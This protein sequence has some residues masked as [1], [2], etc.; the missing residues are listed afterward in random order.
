MNGWAWPKWWVWSM[1]AWLSLAFTCRAFYI[2]TIDLIPQNAGCSLSSPSCSTR[3]WAV[4]HLWPGRWRRQR[5]PEHPSDRSGFLRTSVALKERKREETW[6][7]N[8]FRRIIEQRS[9]FVCIAL[10]GRDMVIQHS[11]KWKQKN[12][13]KWTEERCEDNP[14]NTEGCWCCRNQK[15]MLTHKYKMPL[16]IVPN[17]VMYWKVKFANIYIYYVCPWIFLLLNF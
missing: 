9:E 14:M 17:F 13:I 1:G 11:S 4:G 7:H 8:L 5:R 16:I 3:F 6:L 12:A 2:R 10:L 15:I